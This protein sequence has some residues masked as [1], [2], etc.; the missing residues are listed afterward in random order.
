MTPAIRP[1]NREQSSLRASSD[2][3]ANGQQVRTFSGDALVV[4][5]R[6][7]SRVAR[8]RILARFGRLANQIRGRWIRRQETSPEENWE[9]DTL[10]TWEKESLQLGRAR[11]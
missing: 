2:R 1:A 8:G 10:A 7:D 3:L 6:F 11:F 4:S 9:I 5:F